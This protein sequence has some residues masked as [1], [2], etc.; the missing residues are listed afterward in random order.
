MNTISQIARFR[1][2][3]VTY[4][5]NFGVPAAVRRFNVSRASVYYWR[6]RFN[7]Q[8][9]SLQNKSRRPHRHPN[10]HT[11]QELLLISDKRRRNPH[12]GL[13]VL[14]VKPRERG[15]FRSV[16]SLWRILR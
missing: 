1:Q 15:Y 3:V 2:S 5:F 16:V 8:I 14:W 11:P 13:V 7:G 12:A 9:S 4:S 10:Q 6:S